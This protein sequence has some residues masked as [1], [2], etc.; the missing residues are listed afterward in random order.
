MYVPIPRV[1]FHVTSDTSKVME[2]AVA[3]FD[4]EEQ[5]AGDL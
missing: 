3:D 1:R 4:S 2:T 5:Q